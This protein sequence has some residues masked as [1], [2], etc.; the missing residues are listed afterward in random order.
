V[1][2]P[3]KNALQKYQDQKCNILY[4]SKTIMSDIVPIYQ[5][6]IDEIKIDSDPNNGEVFPVGSINVNG[7]WIQKFSLAKCALDKI[8]YAA[9]IQFDPVNTKRIDDGSDSD[10]VVWQAVGAIRKPD[11]T[12]VVIKKTYEMNLK[13]REAE[14]RKEAED[15]KANNKL[16]KGETVEDYVKKNLIQ[17]RKWKI[18][19][20]ETGAYNRVIRSLVALKSSYTIQELQQPFIVPKF[21]L[22]IGMLVQDPQIKSLILQSAL[23][24][25]SNLFGSSSPEID[26]QSLPSQQTLPSQQKFIGSGEKVTEIENHEND[27]PEPDHQE[28][29]AQEWLNTDDDSRIKRINVLIEQKGFEPKKGSRIPEK[30]TSEEQVQY[31]LF[32]ESL[33]DKP[34]IAEQ[35]P[36]PFD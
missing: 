10:I 26:I 33:D 23:Q 18:P 17:L 28:L 29:H 14:L 9:S 15:K 1:N 2:D 12:I 32:L 30:L 27:E 21:Q 24:S 4:P 25:Q 16:K 22:N 20:A 7:S 35:A 36:L 31:I 11:G 5:M 8:A 13:T 3:I 6:V 19:R 34:A